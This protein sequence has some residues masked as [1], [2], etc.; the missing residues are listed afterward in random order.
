MISCNNNDN[1]SNRLINLSH[2][3]LS[4]I[5]SYLDDNVDRIVFSLVCKRLFNE[6]QR[7]LSFNTNH[8]KIIND[9][10]NKYIPLN[11]YKSIIIDQINRKTK[12]KV[13]VG[14]EIDINYY[15]YM[16]SKDELVDIDRLRTLNID[17][18]VIG[19]EH[20]DENKGN[21]KNLYRLVSD[22]NISKLKKVQS[23]SALPMN[24]TSLSF[25]CLFREDLEP[26]CLPPNL[27]TLKFDRQFYQAIKAGVLP[28]T[29]VKLNFNESFNQPLEP[30]VLPSSLKILKFK[31]STFQQDIKV[32]TFPPQLE[33][34]EFSGHYL[35]IE[36]GALPQT[37]RILEYAPTSW[38]PQIKTLPNLKTLSISYNSLDSQIDLSYLPTS[39][40]RLEIFAPV[41]LVNLNPDDVAS[42]DGLKIKELKL[43]M[44]GYYQSDT[45][46]IPFSIETL[47]VQYKSRC[48]YDKELPS[49]EK[50]IISKEIDC[51]DNL[52][53]QYDM[54]DDN[55]DR[56]VFNLVCKKWFNERHRYLSFN[57]N[58]AS[59]I[60]KNNNNYI[61]LNSYKSIIIDQI[62]RKTKCKV[63]VGNEF[64]INYYDYILS[65]D[66]LVDIDRLRTL[67]IDKVVIGYEENDDNNEKIKNL[68]Q[69]ISDLNI[70]KLKMV[71]T[72]SR[73]PMNITSLSFYNSLKEKLKP[74]CLPPNLKTLKF[75]RQFNQA[76]SVG[77]LPNTLVKLK[78][79]ESF[80]Q[81]LKPGV[82][83]SSLK[84]L[85]FKSF[86]GSSFQQKIKVGT[87]PPQLEELEF[88]GHYSTI[89]D[90]AL[91][92][93]LRILRY[94]PT[95]W[96]PQIK[97]LPNLKTL[98]ISSYTL[99]SHFDLGCLPTS[100]TRLEIFADIKLT[101]VM[102][103]TIRYLDVYNCVYRFDRIFKDRSLYQFDY[104]RLRLNQIASLDGFKIKELELHRKPYRS[105]DN[106]VKIPFGI[107]TLS[108]ELTS[109]CL[110]DKELPSSV[111]KL[112][113]S[114][115]LD[116]QK[117]NDFSCG[118]SIQ[119]LIITCNESIY[120][121]KISAHIT[122]MIF[123]P[124][125][126]IEFTDLR[127]EK[128]WIRMI[129]NQ[130]YLVYCQPIITAIVH[131]SQ[132]HKYLLY[133]ISL[134]RY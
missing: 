59:I 82:L 41:T 55:V 119:Q 95:S 3:L 76:I 70:S 11:S 38:L 67:N 57:T 51:V 10:N 50:M 7:Y 61:H 4:K 88:S 115:G 46:D 81:P 83:P 62:N 75:D 94:A 97:T 9:N 110:Y 91:P 108:L 54:T 14:D 40:T 103:P 89:E 17:K 49:S 36:D 58:H 21:I 26:G 126:L 106:I 23:F 78:L 66:E 123:P 96:L 69:M 12:C 79:N 28:N 111:K 112:I 87:F 130:Y 113:I 99:D 114:Q 109:K 30:G 133:C 104:L 105:V 6:R 120:S 33:E 20:N 25:H 116:N 43:E 100:L 132:L 125:T 15:D 39:L 8:I 90:G 131:K 134:Y 60:L 124:N 56:I 92:Q 71:Q 44:M 45:L 35:T 47:S 122:S 65:I 5:V 34:L 64:K 31:D 129:D 2:L 101:N 118:G 73:L 63:V 85:K 48:I 127:N 72:F 18:V 22:L 16:I 32:G 80:N 24:I 77:V 27:K 117:H 19:F 121:K 37:L 107:E 13:V 74:G 68:Y 42:L 98:S 128:I 1:Q 102:P 29:L 93:T 84:I 53:K 86:K 52:Q